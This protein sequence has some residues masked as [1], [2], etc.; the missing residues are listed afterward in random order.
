MQCFGH[1]TSGG[2]HRC[3]C[4][5]ASH[6]ATIAHRHIITG[7]GQH[8]YVEQG[9]HIELTPQPVVD[10]YG[11]TRRHDISQLD[12]SG[13]HLRKELRLIETPRID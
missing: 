6:D 11:H 12:E 10:Q 13:H 1:T 3:R 4:T 8:S 9:V 7:I 2:T 5:A